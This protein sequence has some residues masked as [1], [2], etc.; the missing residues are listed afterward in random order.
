MASYPNEN[1]IVYGIVVGGN[2]KDPDP[3]QSGGVRV[4]LPSEYG[5]NV[6]IR[7]LPFARSLAEGNQ[8][9]VTNFNPPP[10]HG[11][12]VMCMK[13]PGQAGSGHL[14][15]LGAVPND[16]NKDSTIPGN[17]TGSQLWPAIDKAIKDLTSIRV[18]PNIGSGAAGSKPPKE[19][20]QYYKNE[21]TKYIPST[22]TLWPMN[23]V[24]I[25]QVT[26]VAT[27]T[28]AFSNILTADM[29]SQLP[30]MNMTLGS[31]LTN[32][33]ATLTQQ[34]FNSLPPE[35]GGALNSMSALMQSIEI[36]E[37]GGFNTATKIN[38]A[39]FFNNAVNVLANT[40]TI[41]DLVINF[42]RLQYDTSLYGLESLP[43]VNITMTGGPF[44]DI[45]MQ[46]DA[47]GNITSLAPEPV[48]QLASAFSSLMSN[49]AGFP[50]VFPGANMFGGSSGALNDMFNRLPTGE[51]TK[52]V[53]QMQNNVAPGLPTRDKVNK[54][55]GFAM[56][57]VALGRTA[58]QAVK[59]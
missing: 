36:A 8:K 57:G 35:I 48:Q 50:G 24:Q 28:Q 45:P 9:G 7:H 16:I 58:L 20:G 25:P 4:Y 2:D 3:T 40:R 44:G 52:A 26:N 34:L 14:V 19:K 10:E 53:T 13:M 12:A 11:S 22:G 17:S 43:P 33:P 32:M 31:L 5:K 38:P 55:A 51:L 49:G 54:M 18:P 59:G 46:V 56:T 21:L 29:L 37:G 1:K 42:Q 6:D 23:G 15:V 30:G 27:A 39:V 47:L 41:Y